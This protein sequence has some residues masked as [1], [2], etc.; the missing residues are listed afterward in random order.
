MLRQDNMK[1]SDKRLWNYF[2]EDLGYT[3]RRAKRTISA[4]RNMEPRIFEQFQIWFHTAKFPEEPLF[5]IQVKALC[6]KR[7]LDPVTAFLTVD[8][9]AREPQTAKKALAF[10]YDT[11]VFDEEQSSVFSQIF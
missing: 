3:E 11:L 1:I 6:D 7:G 2:I 8:W 9:V 4:L 5:G 10:G